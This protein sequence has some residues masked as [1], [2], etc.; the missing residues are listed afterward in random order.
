MLN[1]KFSFK[2]LVL[3]HYF[4]SIEVSILPNRDFLLT[5]FKYIQELLQ[6]TK[7]ENNKLSPTSMSTDLHLYARIDEVFDNLAYY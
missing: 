3:L 6:K 7:M 5:Q 4:L 2:Y 1:S